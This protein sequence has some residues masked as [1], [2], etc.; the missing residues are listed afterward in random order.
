MTM[1]GWLERLRPKPL[2]PGLHAYRPNLGGAEARVHLRVDDDG[3]AVALVNASA[4]LRLTASGALMAKEI[5]AGAS[6]DAAAQA[7]ARHFDGTTT[8][9][10][11]DLA[12]L[13]A[14][15]QRLATA[16]GGAWPIEQFG[17]AHD[18]PIEA[19]L[20]LGGRPQAVVAEI[21]RLWDRGV[22]HVTL[23]LVGPVDASVLE[24]AVERAEDLGM[25]CGVRAPARLLSTDALE[26]AAGAGLDC[27]QVPVLSA[28]PAEHDGVLGAGDHLAAVDLLG[29]CLELEVCPVLEVPLVEANADHLEELADLADSIDVEVLALWPA[30]G[31]GEALLDPSDLPQLEAEAERLGESG[32]VHVV[33][34]EPRVV[35]D[36]G[37]AVARGP[38]DEEAR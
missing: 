27:L 8:Q 10:R 29:R 23:H 19:W 20:E 25:I 24:R 18:A 6:D 1:F 26:R 14:T 38:R 15:L 21:D 28:E 13:R 35:A 12:A 5:L 36:V 34:S 22:P 3:S 7:V 4:A 31:E 33:W 17:G 9:I 37:D 2:S 30:L 16:P 11:T 32:R